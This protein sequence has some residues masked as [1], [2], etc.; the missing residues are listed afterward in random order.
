[1][2]RVIVISEPVDG[3]RRRS[4]T[5]NEHIN[6]IHMTDEHSSLQFLERLAWA[7]SDAEEAEQRFEVAL[8]P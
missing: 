4:L 3:R 7:I 6:P 1:M 2:P 5:L 8:T